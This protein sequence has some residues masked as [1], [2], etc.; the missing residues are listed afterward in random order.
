MSRPWSGRTAR[1]RGSQV[2]LRSLPARVSAVAGELGSAGGRGRGGA[3]AALRTR[4]ASGKGQGQPTTRGQGVRSQ[5]GPPDPR[6]A[7]SL[8]AAQRPHSAPARP[9]PLLAPL[10]SPRPGTHHD[11]VL[12]VPHEREASTGIH[13]G[14]GITLLDE[15]PRAVVR[16]ADPGG[17]APGSRRPTQHPRGR[18]AEAVGV[19]GVASSRPGARS[20]VASLWGRSSPGRPPSTCLARSSG[21]SHTHLPNALSTPPP[22][23]PFWAAPPGSP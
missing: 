10:G 5:G 8:S 23:A 13:L 18:G 12:P 17:W 22:W 21:P 16:A 2:S 4:R 7:T 20:S 1:P 3:L 19:G 15:Q 6:S 11:R 14:V 9:D